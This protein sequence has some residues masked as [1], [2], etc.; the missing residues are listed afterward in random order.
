MERKQSG[1]LHLLLFEGLHEEAHSGL[2]MPGPGYGSCGFPWRILSEVRDG[3]KT[4]NLDKMMDKCVRVCEC[5]C[6]RV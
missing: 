5:V 3:A 6:V 2:G 1:K 4:L